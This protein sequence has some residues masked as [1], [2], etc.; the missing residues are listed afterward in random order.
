MDPFF[1]VLIVLGIAGGFIIGGLTG[2]S[3][4]KKKNQHSEKLKEDSSIPHGAAAGL[5]KQD[6]VHDEYLSLLQLWRKKEGGG[7]VFEINEK[8][9]ISK[10]SL[11]ETAIKRLEQIGNEWRTWVGDSGRDSGHA[12]PL[13]ETPNYLATQS[14]QNAPVIKTAGS[15]TSQPVGLTDDNLDKFGS[16]PNRPIEKIDSIADQ[17]NAILQEKIV[18]AGITGRDVRI[19]ESLNHSVIFHVDLKSFH[20]LDEIEEPEILSLIKASV[21]EWE[22]RT[23]NLHRR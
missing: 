5:T 4:A 22:K 1:I 21:A 6:T 11:P 12:S 20:S 15:S 16:K 13:A 7:L 9:Y 18:A 8:F 23:T 17:I 3:I 10:E 2:Y 19:T 14:S